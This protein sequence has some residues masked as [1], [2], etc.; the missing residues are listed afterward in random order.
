MPLDALQSA[1]TTAMMIT[2]RDPCDVRLVADFTA[3]AK[4]SEA[5]GGRTLFTPLTSRSTVPL[6]NLISDVT[7][8]SAI[9]AGNRAR[10]QLYARLPAA[11]VHLSALNLLSVRRRVA[12]QPAPPIATIGGK[13]PGRVLASFIRHLRFA[14]LTRRAVRLTPARTV[15][16]NRIRRGFKRAHGGVTLRGCTTST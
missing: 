14:G 5:P 7:P 1:I 9:R 8:S 4:T 10:N 3:C 6:P 12:A 13:P 15:D 11:I 2:A 16:C